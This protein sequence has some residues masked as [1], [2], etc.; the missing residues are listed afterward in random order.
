MKKKDLKTILLQNA[1]IELFILIF[2]FFGLFAKNWFTISNF[3]L[4]MKQASYVGILAIGVTFPL[5]TAGTDLS[6]GGIMFLSM[7]VGALSLEKGTP[8]SFVI[9]IALIIGVIVGAF[10]AFFIVDLKVMPF[11]GTLA[12]MT[13]LR[14]ITLIISGSKAVDIP[15]YLTINFGSGK[16]FGQIP[17]PLLTFLIL[18]FLFHIILSRTGFGRQVFAC[19]NNLEA[20]KKASVNTRLV[21]YSAYI[22]SGVLAATAGFVSASQIGNVPPAFGQGYEFDA[23]A[24]T[25]LGGTSLMGGAGTIFPGVLIGSITIQMIK[26][27]LTALQVDAY[28]IDIFQALFILLTVVIDGLRGIYIAKRNIR[29]IRME[30]K[31]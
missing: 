20:A 27:G 29:Y 25:V 13:M 7:T 6:V 21:L 23:I 5:I 24:A 10:N 18:L 8:L 11:I 12:S 15:K 19:G 17:Y 14:G 31:G 3:V 30:E 1:N 9:L 4:I 22:I 16:L 26:T 2:I 28:L